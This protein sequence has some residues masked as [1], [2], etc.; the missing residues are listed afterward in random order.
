VGIV[1]N[2]PSTQNKVNLITDKAVT[3]FTLTQVQFAPDGKHVVYVGLDAGMPRRLG[4]IHCMNR[5]S[6]IFC[7]K[8]ENLVKALS[9]SKT[10]HDS[11]SESYDTEVSCLTNHCW[12]A[13][14]P[15][16]TFDHCSNPKMV[17]LASPQ[18]D[19]HSGNVELHIADWNSENICKISSRILV[20]QYVV[21]AS[22]GPKVLGMGFPGLFCSQLPLRG[23]THDGRYVYVNT[24]WGSA[25]KIVKVSTDDGSISCVRLK[26]Q[27]YLPDAASESILYVT[28]K[29]DVVV[30]VSEPVLPAKIGIIASNLLIDG[31]IIS[32]S[33]ISTVHVSPVA[34]TNFYPL[35]KGRVQDDRPKH[36]YQ[37]LSVDV[38]QG[39]G[40]ASVE[41]SL[42]IQGILLLPRIDDGSTEKV[43]LIVVPHGG[44]HSCSTT[45]YMPMY[46]FLC[47]QG[48]YAILHVNYRGSTGFG[49]GAL[50]S[51]TGNIGSQDVEDVKLLTEAALE[52]NKQTLDSDRVGKPSNIHF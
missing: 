44:P 3:E 30:S 15:R 50:N 35:N 51:I 23:F 38:P 28:A 42:P 25:S 16:F 5:R 32:P 52:R 12:M 46:S 19:T 39:S 45:A 18:M 4:L 10:S 6:W 7:S 49:K 34:S 41:A 13:T 47:Q 40:D 22:D 2:S 31:D 29:D 33:W 48:R 1:S 43:P 9:D 14:S 11:I 24:Q 21:P 20:D 27:N 37:V 8:V 26:C 36:T 17:Y